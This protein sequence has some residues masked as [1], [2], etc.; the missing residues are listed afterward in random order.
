MRGL[1]ILC[2][3]LLLT[4][5]AYAGEAVTLSVKEETWTNADCRKTDTCDLQEV[6]FRAKQYKV[7]VHGT[8]SYGTGFSAHYRTQDIAALE[9]YGFVQT[10]RGCV[11]DSYEQAGE[12]RYAFAYNR[13]FY[14]E[15]IPFRHAVQVF[16]TVDKDPFYNSYDDLPR[17][18]AYQWNR[19]PGSIQRQTREFYG[20]EKPPSPELY[21]LDYPG[22]AFVGEGGGVKNLSLEFETCVY[23]T[24]DVPKYA[25]PEA[26]PLPGA[27]VCFKWVSS[28]VFNH[29]TGE[30]AQSRGIHPFCSEEPP[31]GKLKDFPLVRRMPPGV[32]LKDFGP[33]AAQLLGL[34]AAASP[35]N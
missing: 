8:Y 9:K 15:V 26:V 12:V 24:E 27:L 28:H 25:A 22:T 3:T 17:H 2:A 5:N 32:P 16:D 23:R 33:A 11:F 1:G 29:R 4:A 31:P 19:V 35:F 13:E 10:I 18:F 20:R 21:V 6:R 7:L 34:E 30:F 14:G